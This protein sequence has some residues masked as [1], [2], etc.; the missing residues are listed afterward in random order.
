MQNNCIVLVLHYMHVHT[1]DFIEFWKLYEYYRK[2]SQIFLCSSVG[3]WFSTKNNRSHCQRVVFDEITEWPR[4]IIIMATAQRAQR[5]TRQP[6]GYGYCFRVFRRSA[7]IRMR[8]VEGSPRSDRQREIATLGSHVV[9]FFHHY[10]NRYIPSL[11]KLQARKLGVVGC[12][13]R[14]KINDCPRY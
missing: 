14:A 11:L 3:I 4:P 12:W 9:S 13:P 6:S 8:H 7:E 5:V 2:A 1:S 10:D